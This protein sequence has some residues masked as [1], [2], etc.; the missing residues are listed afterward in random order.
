VTQ[1]SRKGKEGKGRRK[2]TRNRKEVGGTKK[3]V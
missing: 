1:M 3:L 2:M